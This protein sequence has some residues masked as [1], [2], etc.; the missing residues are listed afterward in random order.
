[1]PTPFRLSQAAAADY[2]AL[3]VYGIAT[4]G[5]LQADCYCDGLDTLFEDLARHPRM[6]APVDHIRR[7]YRRA[8]YQSH[9]VYYLIQEDGLLIVRILGRQDAT[10]ELPE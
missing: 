10:T 4:F 7:G 5:E 2:R 6:G 8:V 3:Y 1:M 9:S